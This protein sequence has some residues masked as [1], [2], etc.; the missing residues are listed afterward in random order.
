MNWSLQLGLEREG[1]KS[2]NQWL[3]ARV[4]N[5]EMSLQV[6]IMYHDG[7]VLVRKKTRKL[8]GFGRTRTKVG[9]RLLLL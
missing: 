6:R 4:K 1:E 7:L 9:E 2:L 8:F 5:K 3:S